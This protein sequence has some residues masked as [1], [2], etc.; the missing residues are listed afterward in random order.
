V[1]RHLLVTARDSKLWVSRPV[2]RSETGLSTT[3]DVA[4]E[5]PLEIRVD[6]ETL[7]VTMRT[8]GDDEVLALGFLLSEGII[9][10]AADVARVVH[11]GRPGDEGYG[12]VVDVASGPGVSLDVERVGE[13]RRGTITTSACGVC[14]RRTIDDLLRRVGPLPAGE[15]LDAAIVVDA[16][17]SLREI[18]PAF[19]RT[20]GVH[21][22][23]VFDRLGARLAGFEDV[24]RHNA[25]DK[26]LG[27]LLRAGPLPGAAA[28]LVVSGRASYEILHK[29]IVAGLPVVASVSAPSSL[30]VDVATRCGV[31]LACFVRNGGM[32]VYG[33]SG[34]VRFPAPGVSG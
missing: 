15:P 22:A 29:A 25:V 14:G 18:Q 1:L 19:A 6:G 16:V 24:G 7:A 21:A 27:H 17:R 31:A 4:V 3:D 34:R 12:N 20:G 2:L 9:T 33:D 11:C 26:V 13:T 32:A 23:A 10:S 30:A 8:P 5:E 28:F